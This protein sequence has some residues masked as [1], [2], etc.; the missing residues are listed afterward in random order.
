MIQTGLSGNHGTRARTDMAGV[1][2]VKGDGIENIEGITLIISSVEK[3]IRLIPF[4]FA[5][6][7]QKEIFTCCTA[8]K[9]P[10]FLR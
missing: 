7:M 9:I 5:L 8:L 6:C 4:I 3:G 2:L 1:V 10:V